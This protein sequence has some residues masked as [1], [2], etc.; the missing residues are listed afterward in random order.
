[1][2]RPTC[3]PTLDRSMS[4]DEVESKKRRRTSTQP[5]D[6][7]D[8]LV[9]RVLEGRY[10]LERVLNAGGM[11]I[12]FEA[13]QLSVNRQVAVKVLKPTLTRDPSLVERFQLEVD[14]VAQMAHPN[15]VGLIDTGIDTTGL[16]YLV[17]EFVEGKTLRQALRAGD[18]K[19]WEIL[20]VYGQV[21]NALI[22][23]H[24]QQIIHRDLKFD[25]IMVQR[26]RDQ[27]IHVKLL[28]FGVA[29]LLSWD[30]RLTQGGQV[31]GTPGI[32][33]P[34]LVDGLDPSPR[35]D[36]YSLG[37]LMFTTFAGQ[38]PFVADNDLA[39]MQAHKTEPLPNLKA[40]VGAQV[41]EEVIDLSCELLAKAP[42]FRPQSATMV[43]RRLEKMARRIR[44]RF[45]DAT[46]YMPPVTEGLEKPASATFDTDIKRFTQV[47]ETKGA[48]GD[49]RGWIG[50]IFPR[51]VVAPMT[52]TA[53][54]SLILMI[55]VVIMIY[56]F[57][58]QVSVTGT[59][60]AK[61][62]DDEQEV[63]EESE[64]SA[65]ATEYPQYY[66]FP[67]PMQGPRPPTP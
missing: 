63:V 51:P 43:R 19:L 13:T 9:G 14:M 34:E 46:S 8:L 23:T 3:A 40:L 65:E 62:A 21:C 60:A 32:V 28:D 66:D 29:R 2:R 42:E 6:A 35:S 5:M 44:E 45:P 39:L 37:V 49:D 61:E 1:M 47:G 15:I 17:M 10:R 31:A 53:S 33:A 36:L 41:P 25:N 24:G 11:G 57:F 20:E 22:E 50:W 54:L 7:P 55:L 18:L 27:S 4:T 67:E 26:M 52:V 59:N 12:I 30:K 16:T 38:A 48:D 58:E 64:E 56:L